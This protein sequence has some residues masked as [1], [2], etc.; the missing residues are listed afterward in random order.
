MPVSKL[1]SVTQVSV[2]L[3]CAKST[4]RRLVADGLLRA[5]RIGRRSIRISEG[6]LQAYLEVGANMPT[7]AGQAGTRTRESSND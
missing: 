1:L 7:S 2:K 3:Q 4:V 5:F 6:D